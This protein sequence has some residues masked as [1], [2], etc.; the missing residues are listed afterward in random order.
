MEEIKQMF[1][2][3]QNDIRETNSSIKILEKNLTQRIEEKFEN[4][5]IR[6]QNLEEDSER[7]EK[8]IDLI[9]KIQ[10]QRNIVI[11]GIPEGER[12]YNDLSEKVLDIFNKTMNSNTNKAE[13]EFLRR[14]GRKAEKARPVVVTL[15]TMGKKIDILK[16][17]RT[18]RGTI[19]AIAEDF[20][21]KIL[22][23]RKLLQETA[24]LE[25]EKGNTVFIKYDKLVILPITPN[26]LTS[27]EQGGRNNKRMLSQ[28]P[29]DAL[30]RNNTS[31]NH[32]REKATTQT[33]KKNKISSYWPRD[34]R[35][36]QTSKDQKSDL[37]SNSCSSNND[38]NIQ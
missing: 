17:K 28:S 23:T 19:Y 3:I 21:P 36:A 6:I 29:S 10:R 32:H 24:K 5:H 16:Q 14:I 25:R 34:T 27:T 37:T 11:F 2:K 22:E 7:K 35:N 4:L 38:M 12:G 30:S 1:E 31:N 26:K 13:I 15:G 33:L 20:P 8:R 9:E 18:L